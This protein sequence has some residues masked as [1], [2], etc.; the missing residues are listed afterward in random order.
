MIKKIL[1]ANREEIAVKLGDCIKVED[2]Y[3]S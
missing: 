1:I 3:A 2:H